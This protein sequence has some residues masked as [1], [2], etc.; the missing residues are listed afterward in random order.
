M[1]K[2]N[3]D[4]R[5]HVMWRGSPVPFDRAWT[6]F[7]RWMDAIA[8]DQAAASPRAKAIR[9]R[10]AAATDGCWTADAGFLPEPQTFSREP[11]TACN[12][13]FPSYGFARLVAGGPLAADILKCR[14][15]P[16]D[17]KAY[18]VRFNRDELARLRRVFPDGVCDWRRPGAEQTAVVPWASFGPAKAGLVFDVTGP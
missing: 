13:R 6:V 12:A 1:A 14:L 11:K 3:G 7:V 18:A 2:A 8:A 16:V 4:A 15:K 10:P 9:D 5:N 17:P